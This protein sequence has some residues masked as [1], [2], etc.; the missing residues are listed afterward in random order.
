[1]W[2]CVVCSCELRLTVGACHR[3]DG[4][5][6]VEA[7]GS[8]AA[9]DGNN[10]SPSATSGDVLDAPLS[11]VTYPQIL[12][13]SGSDLG[14]SGDTNGHHAHSLLCNNIALPHRGRRSAGG[15]KGRQGS[16]C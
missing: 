7:E 9:D 13:R 5:V 1:M 14:C 2:L 15:D 16:F 6:M 8:A 11:C 3:G 12:G 10:P 4:F